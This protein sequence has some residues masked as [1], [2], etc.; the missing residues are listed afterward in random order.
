MKIT[1]WRRKLIANLVAG[2]LIAPSAAI[3]A[4]LDTNLVANP[5]FESVD[6][7]TTGAYGAPLILNW[8][9]GPGFAYSHNPTVT[10]IP[11]YADGTDP[12]GAGSWYFTSNNNPGSPTGDWRAPD[13][14]YQD[15]NVSTGATG[16]QIAT[17]EAAYKLSA[18]MSGYLNDNDNGN[19]RLDFKNS[20]GTTIGFAQISD[21]DFG[22][23][24]VWS[25]SSDISLVPVGTASI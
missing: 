15:I 12:P 16:A 8:S 1:N 18:W 3:A 6:S 24:N 21:P 22:P 13:L 11:D 10:G 25:L 7:G 23:N 14:V 4:N 19:V 5:G 9:G 2:G 20:G 17:G